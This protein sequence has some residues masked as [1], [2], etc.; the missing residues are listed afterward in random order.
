[1]DFFLIDAFRTVLLGLMNIFI[2]VSSPI[3]N[4]FS[5]SWTLRR[6]LI[7][8]I[9]I[10]SYKFLKLKVLEADEFSGL[11]WYTVLAFLLCYL[12]GF[13]ANNFYANVVLDKETHCLPSSLSLLQIFYKQ[14][15]MRPKEMTSS[16]HHWFISSARIIPL[17]NMLTIPY[18]L[19]MQRHLS[20][21]TSRTFCFTL[22][23]TLASKLIIPILPWF[24]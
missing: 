4:W 3:K 16:L 11:R 18:W 5:W 13:Q 17:F 1:M 19:Q 14:C 22:L 12:M 9:M 8:S 23:H 21:K 15:W 10:L 7:C 20:F 24:Q 6:H 2:N